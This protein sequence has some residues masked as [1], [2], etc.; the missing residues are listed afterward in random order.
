MK[1]KRILLGGFI[2]MSAIIIAVSI[3]KLDTP[4]DVKPAPSSPPP[5]V[6]EPEL[7]WQ[8]NGN[9][10]ENI[11]QLLEGKLEN[12]SASGTVLSDANCEADEQGISRCHN[13]I[14]LS[15]QQKIT[16]IN[17]H[18][19]NNYACLGPGDSVS[20]EPYSE[21]WLKVIKTGDEQR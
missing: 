16:V 4:G 13:E 9:N 21:G 15:D 17:V 6:N 14:E 8:Q 11:T 19:M 18:N 10:N 3:W 12:T 1:K 5:L 20:I 7:D 2:A